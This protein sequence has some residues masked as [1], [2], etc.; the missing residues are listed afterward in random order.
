[1]LSPWFH[2]LTRAENPQARIYAFPHAGAGAAAIKPLASVAPPSLDVVGIRLP[3]RE[4]R[5]MEEGPADLSDIVSALK[6]AFLQESATTDVPFALMGQCSGAA[7]AFE[8]AAA[9]QED[10]PFL[11]GVIICSRPAP[12][13]LVEQLPSDWMSD[14]QF[15][16]EIVKL[17]GVQEEIAAEPVLMELLTPII[18]RD[19]S[20]TRGYRRQPEDGISL[21]LLAVRG[22]GDDLVPESALREWGQFTNHNFTMMSVSANHFPFSQA[23]GELMNGV[24]RWFSK[25]G[26]SQC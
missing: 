8:V 21:P 6:T 19:F 3:G 22:T 1:M 2:R 25:G 16:E 20:M 5:I 13:V 14:S 18:R 9:L 12:S 23:P 24:N 11:S 4:T 7:L 10:A 17:G 15:I 26:H